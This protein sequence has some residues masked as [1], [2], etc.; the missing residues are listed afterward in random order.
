VRAIAVDNRSQLWIGT[1]KGLRILSNSSSFLTEDQ[2]KTNPI[3]ILE[4]GLAQELLYEQF[5]TDIVVDGANNKWVGTADSGVF[6]LS[7][8]GQETK[9]HFTT[10]NSPLPSNTINDIDI[11]NSTGE[12]FIATNKGLISF[13][14]TATEANEDLKEP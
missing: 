3:I 7:P 13:K 8:N 4:D 1:I 2:M 9:Y 12:V 11:N 10:N 5:I 14:G 6:L